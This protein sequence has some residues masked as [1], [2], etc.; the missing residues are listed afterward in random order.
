MSATGS[1]AASRF[2]ASLNV[3]DLTRS[4]QFYRVLLGREP[5]KQ[6]KDYAKF[7]VDDPPLVLSLIPGHPTAGGALN[8]IGLRLP[9]S[10][11]L[12]EVQARLEASG[13]RTKREEGVECCHSRQTKFWVTD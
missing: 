11:M 1:K 12:V 3:S 7:E 4:V 2:H 13:I 6:K 5:V 8:H 10:E 9:D